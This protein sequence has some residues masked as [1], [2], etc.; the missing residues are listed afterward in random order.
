MPFFIFLVPGLIAYVLH[1]RGEL[2]LPL[3][4]E[5]QTDYNAAFPA[6]VQ[7]IMPMGLRGLL[8]GGLL[9]ALMTSLASVYNACI[10]KIKKQFNKI[11]FGNLHAQ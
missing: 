4:A 6:M 11:G 3:N 2:I 7:Q 8:A 10:M 9:A 5:G 1:D